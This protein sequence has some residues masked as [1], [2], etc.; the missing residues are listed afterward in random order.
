MDY[1]H[2]G[3]DTQAKYGKPWNYKKKV[4]RIRDCYLAVN[5]EK[6]IVRI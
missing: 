2:T 1:G 5:C 6:K 3:K 4:R